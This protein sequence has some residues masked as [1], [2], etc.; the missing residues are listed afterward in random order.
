M[1]VIANGYAL[2]P[3][4][5]ER[6]NFYATTNDLAGI[7]EHRHQHEIREQFRWTGNAIAILS[8]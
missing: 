6:A 7:W 1:S 8:T 3:S 2:S 4:A 5:L